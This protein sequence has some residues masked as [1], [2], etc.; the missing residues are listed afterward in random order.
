MA[1][2]RMKHCLLP[3]VLHRV[4]PSGLLQVVLLLALLLGVAWP[5]QAQVVIKE[6]VEI[7]KRETLSKRQDSPDNPRR[8]PLKSDWAT[9]YLI[10]FCPS[11]L[12]ARPTIPL[13][14]LR[15][16]A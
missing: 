15:P 10:A 6:R 1:L 4:P 16:P 7:K 8:G 14:N 11:S 9:P 3:P 12:N 2:S 13:Q 5:A